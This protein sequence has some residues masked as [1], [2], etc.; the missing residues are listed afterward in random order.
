MIRKSLLSAAV[1]AGLA[2]SP[3]ALAL[4]ALKPVVR[5]PTHAAI[6]PPASIS[7]HQ[8]ALGRPLPVM[9]RFGS[10]GTGPGSGQF[11]GCT[12]LYPRPAGC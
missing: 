2:W 11:G 10:T 9:H 3:A 8:A 5:V 1:A 4:A 12:A 7:R 6:G